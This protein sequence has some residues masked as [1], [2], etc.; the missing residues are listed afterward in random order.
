MVKCTSLE[1]IMFHSHIMSKYVILLNG[2]EI[3]ISR[4]EI[5]YPFCSILCNTTLNIKCSIAE[6]VWNG[7]ELCARDWWNICYACSVAKT[8]IDCWCFNTTFKGH[9][10]A[11]S[12]RPVFI[13][14]GSRS[15]LRKRQ[16][17]DRKTDNPDWLTDWLK[18]MDVRN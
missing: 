4:A 12:W 17:F 8:L 11:I 18:W 9:F 5:T 1:Q 16:T 6:H 2:H 15:A 14:G 3:S 7:Y 13:G 10:L